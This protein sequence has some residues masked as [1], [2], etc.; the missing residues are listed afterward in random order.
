MNVKTLRNKLAKLPGSAEVFI[1]TDQGLH[2]RLL[3]IS[4]GTTWE[5]GKRKGKPVLIP[6]SSV[7]L[8]DFLSMD[9]TTNL[10]H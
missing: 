4:K 6:S 10:T 1:A 7:I 5:T 9:S 2:H 8:Y 3:D